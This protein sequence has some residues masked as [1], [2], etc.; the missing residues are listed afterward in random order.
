MASLAPVVDWRIRR[1]AGP[2]A[3]LVVDYH[4][5]RYQGFPPGRHLGL[6]SGQLTMVISLAEPLR[7]VA[8]PDPRQS[9]ANLGTLVAGL[10]T[11]PAVIA[12]RGDQYGIELDLTPAG[13]RSLLGLPAAAV[14]GSVVELSDLVGRD[15]AAVLA[16]RLVVAPDWPARFA[17]LDETLTRRAGR[18]GPTE[19]ALARAWRM[20]A[21]S[22][23]RAR[24]A[25]VASEVG[26]SRR[27]LATRF[28]AE[29]GLTPK[30]AA[31][32]IRFERAHTVLKGPN[33][34]TLADVAAGCGYYDQAHLARDWNQLAGCPPSAWLRGE[35]FP[36]FQ[37]ATQDAAALS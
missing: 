2:L 7:L 28:V 13:A 36:L 24:V 1:P 25:D 14:A 23:G 33:R 15:A 3:G 21:D 37:A 20:I 22:G 34:P 32:V 10:H 8:M 31:R 30:D 5:Y 18:L 27:H 11:R 4:G 19:P 17:I 35:E 12:H 9:P 16:E 26:W 29:Y 6:P